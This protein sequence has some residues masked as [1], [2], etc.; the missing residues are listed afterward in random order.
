MKKMAKSAV[1]FLMVFTMVFGL[2]QSG[3]VKTQADESTAYT[4]KVNLGTN[5]TTIYK[6]GKAI[7]AM[8]CSPSSETPTG[9]FYIPVKYRWHDMIGNCYAQYCSRITTGILFHSVWYYKKFDKS[10]M[11]VSAYNVMGQ[12]ASHGCVRLLCKDAKWIYDHCAV[13]TKIV[14]FWGNS[15]DDPIARPGFTRITNG[16]HTDWDPTDPDPANPYK[17]AKP[18]IVANEKKIEYG[19]DIKLT[20]L[21]TIKDSAGNVLDET[22]AEIKTKGKVNT[23]KLGKYKVTYSVTDSLGGKKKKTFTFKVVDTQSPVLSGAKDKKN[24]AMGS[25]RNVLSGVKAKAVS[26]K[27]LTSKIKVSALYKKSKVK[28]S[29]GIITFTKEGTYKITY[30]V[31]GSNKKVTTK[32]VKYQVNDQRVQFALKNKT[33]KITAGSKFK[34]LDYVDYVTTYDGKSI[35]AKKNVKVTGDIDTSKAGTYTLTLTA[36]YKGRAYTARTLKLKVVVKEAEETTSAAEET[37]TPA[38]E[39][40]SAVSDETSSQVESTPA[41][42]ETT[43]VEQPTAI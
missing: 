14:I 23:K 30:K 18:V 4:I 8:I 25:E 16:K 9:T 3:T 6:G 10:T 34:A 12:K 26:G 29:K 43:T 5:C 17:K 24:I 40:S 28:V 38:E 11:S 42:D 27:N 37:T 7:K 19:T 41:A 33:V 1:A 36:T 22:D 21:V 2:A 20:D 39:S 32:T 13:G 35:S 15:K 31:T